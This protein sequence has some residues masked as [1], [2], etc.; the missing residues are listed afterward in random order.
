MIPNVLTILRIF[1]VP[2]LVAALV[3]ETAVY[4]VGG[5]VLA[6][7][8]RYAFRPR[9]FRLWIAIHEVTHRAQFTGVPWMR[10]YFMSLVRQGAQSGSCAR[11]E[12]DG[13]VPPARGTVEGAP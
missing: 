13:S 10:E 6:L 11:G 4:Y 2:L 8:K 9:D 12:D 7:E 3:Q 5:N 1:F